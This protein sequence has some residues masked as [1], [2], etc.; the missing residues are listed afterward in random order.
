[1]LRRLLII[2]AIIL[3]LLVLRSE[4]SAAPPDDPVV[5][6]VRAGDT[7]SAIAIRYGVS[8]ANL[9]LLNGLNSPNLIF[10]GQQL[11]IKKDST[12]PTAQLAK[13]TDTKTDGAAAPQ[14][15]ANPD[16]AR[17]GGP[18]NPPPPTDSTAPTDGKGSG[19]DASAGDK[20]KRALPPGVSDS[21]KSG[22]WIEV[23]LSKQEMVAWEGETPVLVSRVST[24]V[25]A[26]PTVLGTFRIYTKIRSQAMSGPGYY[27]PNVPYVMFFHG[28][29][30]LH[31]TYW[32]SN[33]GHPMSHGCV[34][35]PTNIAAWVYDW[36]T[37]GTPVFV[38][39]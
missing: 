3:A 34:N 4:A 33:F 37:I 26:H 20:P 8:T 2:L 38:H 39:K 23:S 14:A 6:V 36:A 11:I 35:L 25:P 21:V 7:L 5:Y 28:A 1:M 16:Q 15:A 27:L 18:T 19:T 22:R 10:I 9:M 13:S 32:H 17:A 30:G 12:A 24:G 29:Y 31:G